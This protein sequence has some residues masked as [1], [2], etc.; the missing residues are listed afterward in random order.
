M[1]IGINNNPFCINFTDSLKNNWFKESNYTINTGKGGM[2][3]FQDALDIS[4]ER[5]GQTQ[6]S[7]SLYSSREEFIKELLVWD[8]P[9]IKDTPLLN[10]G[11]WSQ[12]RSSSYSS[13]KQKW[14][15]EEGVQFFK[16]NDIP[17]RIVEIDGKTM[18]ITED[19]NPER[20]NLYIKN[21]KI[22]KITYG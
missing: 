11:L 14:D 9:S 18:V 1:P 16:E 8:T 4:A 15:K 12:M 22:I 10:T 7:E 5:L 17:Y 3:A 20:A 2:K 6:P 21:D 19:F 13:N